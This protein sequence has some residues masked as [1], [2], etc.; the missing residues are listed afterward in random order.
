LND[1]QGVQS[2]LN[3]F[4]ELYLSMAADVRSTQ[5]Q[6][7]SLKTQRGEPTESLDSKMD[8]MVRSWEKR[9]REVVDYSTTLQHLVNY[10][11]QHK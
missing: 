2:L 11:A 5:Q 6:L 7:A 8:A 3:K 4:S 9:G 10:E 1:W